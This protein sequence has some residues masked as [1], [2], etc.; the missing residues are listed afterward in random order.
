MKEWI[1]IKC[2]RYKRF[3]SNN[4][5]LGQMVFFPIFEIEGIEIKKII[6]KGVV[7]KRKD[8]ILKILEDGQIFYLEETDVYPVDAPVEFIY[9]MFGE[10]F[11]SLSW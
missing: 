5:R 1:C 2:K 3:N 7:L 8:S 10:C 9:N 6:R 4:L 11:C